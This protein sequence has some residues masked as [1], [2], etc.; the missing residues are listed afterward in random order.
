MRQVQF[1]MQFA[2]LSWRMS[3][4]TLVELFGCWCLPLGSMQPNAE[5]RG[6][7]GTCADMHVSFKFIITR[8]EE[9]ISL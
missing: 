3:K 4:V 6:C 7:A 1:I 2:G 9:R 8:I 5:L